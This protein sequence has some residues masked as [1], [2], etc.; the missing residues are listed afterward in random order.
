MRPGSAAATAPVGPSPNP[1]RQTPHTAHLTPSA[2]PQRRFG[3]TFASPT[4]QCSNATQGRRR[5][6]TSRS[7]LAQERWAKACVDVRDAFV[8]QD[9]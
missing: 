5:D 3:R 8:A 4:P 6:G 7:P 1:P 2:Q 9:E